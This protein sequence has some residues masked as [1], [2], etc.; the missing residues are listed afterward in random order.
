MTLGQPLPPGMLIITCNATRAGAV[1][2]IKLCS[3]DPASMFALAMNLSGPHPPEKNNTRA[4]NGANTYGGGCLS[5]L[6]GFCSNM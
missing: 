1:L 4:Q 3:P 6:L 5:C 2:G